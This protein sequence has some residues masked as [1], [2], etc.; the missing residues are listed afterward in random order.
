VVLTCGSIH[1]GDTENIIPDEVKFKINIRTYDQ[2]V[3]EKVLKS[4][5][6]IIYSECEASQT[7]KPPSI[8]SISQFPLTDNDQATVNALRGT[9]QEYFGDSLS[10]QEILPGSEDVS[11]LARPNNTPYAYWF[12][13][14]TSAKQWDDA[15]RKNT[16]SLLPR[17]HSSRFAPAI[18]P[19]L[20]T[21]TD[22]LS[23]AALTFLCP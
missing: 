21:G 18:E 16:T 14:G 11:N 19:T 5:R 22:A 8:T 10:E 6:Q 1:G 3:R 2:T 17:N 15:E 23:L 7:P 9:F 20:K 12:F 13:G 4:M